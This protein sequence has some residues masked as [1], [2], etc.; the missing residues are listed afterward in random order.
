[1]ITPVEAQPTDVALDGERVLLVFLLGVGVVVT[2]VADAAGLL[3]NPEVQANGHRVPHVQVAV[4]LRRKPGHD[5][6]AV[7][8]TLKIRRDLA[9]DEVGPGQRV[10]SLRHSGKV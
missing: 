9:P 4:G 7:R 1:V 2:Q 8:T 6:A 3:G 5:P 10:G